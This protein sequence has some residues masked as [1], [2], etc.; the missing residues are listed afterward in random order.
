MLRY[1]ASTAAD[2]K[3]AWELMACPARWHQWAPHVRGAWGL[4]DREV[5]VGRNGWV[6]LLGVVPV[7]ATVVAKEEGRSWTWRVGGVVLM[8]H[9]VDPRPGGGCVVAVTLRAP[10][11]VEVAL[12]LAYGPVVRVMVGRLAAAAATRTPPA[13]PRPSGP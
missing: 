11:P 2:P 7:Q 5:Q 9:V 8:D 4:G 1:A 13:S 3:I 10:G 12:R 6:R